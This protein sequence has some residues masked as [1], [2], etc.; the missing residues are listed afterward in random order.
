MWS[1]SAWVQ[2]GADI[3]GENTGDQIIGKYVD[4]SADGSVMAINDLVI[5][6][7]STRTSVTGR[8]FHQAERAAFLMGQRGGAN[9]VDPVRR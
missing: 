3:D 1:G 5:T 6:I 4:L 7:S 8:P 9:R 2:R